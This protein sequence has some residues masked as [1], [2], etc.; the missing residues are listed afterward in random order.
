[1]QYSGIIRMY[2]YFIRIQIK[3]EMMQYSGIIRMYIYFAD[4]GRIN[5]LKTESHDSPL[6]LVRPL[7]CIYT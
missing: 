4:G 6:R 2:V 1:M 7:P 5:F 3:G